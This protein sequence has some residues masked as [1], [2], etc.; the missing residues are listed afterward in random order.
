MASTH[1]L[2]S[3]VQQHLR[4]YDR[5]V[6]ALDKPFYQ[7]ICE[8]V[9]IHAVEP[10]KC[11]LRAM[12][13]ELGLPYARLKR[14]CD[15][16]V[17]LGVLKPNDVGKARPLVMK[18]LE[19]AL[20]LGYLSPGFSD[21]IEWLSRSLRSRSEGDTM[22]AAE[23]LATQLS[24]FPR[25]LYPASQFGS[26]TGFCE[27]ALVAA[28]LAAETMPDDVKQGIRERLMEVATRFVAGTKTSPESEPEGREPGSSPVTPSEPSSPESKPM[29][30]EP[31]SPQHVIEVLGFEPPRG[32]GSL[33]DAELGI[34]RARDIE[35]FEDILRFFGW[36][37]LFIIPYIYTVAPYRFADSNFLIWAGGIWG[38]EVWFELGCPDEYS[39]EQAREGARKVAEKQLR[40]ILK[41]VDETVRLIREY[42][43]DGA[44]EVINRPIRLHHSGDAGW[45]EL[46][47][48][49]TRSHLLYQSIPLAC[50][51]LVCSGMDGDPSLISRA[52][53]AYRLL[54]IAVEQEFRGEKAEGLTLETFVERQ[55]SQGTGGEQ[56][57]P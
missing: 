37:P 56:T 50:A 7:V 26:V 54:R 55:L 8:Y 6:D 30:R 19:K 46:K 49:V 1:E 35:G 53:S 31:L 28:T 45:M 51:T 9:M 57:R 52:K 25:F 2:K 36:H 39:E 12:E 13:R 40:Y 33:R 48:E 16:L 10:T 47:P 14:Y 5:N 32:C 21:F 17:E 43:V 41:L 11:T 27:Q 3:K 23:R 44:L 15:R 34:K 20:R 4:D 18:D 42:G 38:R 29:V 22:V 24:N